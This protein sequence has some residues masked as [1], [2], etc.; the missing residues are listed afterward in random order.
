MRRLFVLVS[1]AACA[2]P[3]LISPPGEAVV[4]K[5]QRI[6]E[7]APD[8]DLAEATKANLGMG[9]ALMAKHPDGN[10]VFSPYSITAA[11]SRLEAGAKANTLDGIVTALKQTLSPARHHRAMNTLE[12]ALASRG[13]NAKGADGRPFRLVVSNQLFAQKGQHLEAP[14]LDTL[15]QEYGSSVQLLDFSNDAARVNLNRWVEQRTEGKITELFAPASLLD[16]RLAI[17]NTLYFNAAWAGAF[18]KSKTTREPFHLLEGSA[19]VAMMRNSNLDGSSAVVDGTQVL[20]LPYDG[21]ELSL[22]VIAPKLGSFGS[23]VQGFDASAYARLTDQLEP[24]PLDVRLPKFAFD[25]GFDLAADLIDLGMSDAFEGRADFSGLTGDRTLSISGAV[26]KAVIVLDENG[27][28]AAAATGFAGPPS[29]PPQPLE[30]VID[31]PF[32]F[33]IRDVKTRV[34]LF[35]G[36]VVNP[37]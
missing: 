26:H 18:E 33:F 2:D 20:E 17:V 27:T 1:L 22:I 5:A 32:L 14:F 34:V 30:V 28:V 19:E 23:F 31:R 9:L 10:F 12:A 15:A 6:T 36:R 29:L 3:R 11:T 21:G 25:S 4:S 37:S 24:H 16:A 35:A 7:P 13:Q 8:E